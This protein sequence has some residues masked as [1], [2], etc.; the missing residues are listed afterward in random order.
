MK[1]PVILD[2]EVEVNK[3]L[4]TEAESIILNS[5]ELPEDVFTP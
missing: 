3:G 1:E 5:A 4:L 2:V